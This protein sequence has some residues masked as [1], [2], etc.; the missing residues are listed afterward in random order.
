MKCSEV[1]VGGTYTTKINR[2]WTRVEVVG[3]K[4]DW[5]GKAVLLV[6]RTGE[7]QGRVFERSAAKLQPAPARRP[8]PAIDYTTVGDRELDDIAHYAKYADVRAG[9]SAEM[10]RRDAESLNIPGEPSVSP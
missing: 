6:R 9:A 10:E 4:T 1:T 7:P 8:K 5:K 2:A 3:T